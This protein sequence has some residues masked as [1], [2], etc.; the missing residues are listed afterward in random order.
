MT[1]PSSHQ[2]P[3]LATCL[4]ASK[5]A[6][7]MS[8]RAA[9]EMCG[10]SKCWPPATDGGHLCDKRGE[11]CV[12]DWDEKDAGYMGL[13]SVFGRPK[14][15]YGMEPLGYDQM[16]R[17]TWSVADRVDDMNANGVLGSLCFPTFPGFAGQR[18]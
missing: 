7:P 4:S 14:E 18:F 15:E 17:G 5:G 6:S 1:M 3:L 10:F 9:N 13:M 11:C 8:S 16:R 2:T 12:C